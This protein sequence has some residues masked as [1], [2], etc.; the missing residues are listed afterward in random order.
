MK[1]NEALKMK[2]TAYFSGFNGLEIKDIEYGVD[3]YVIYITGAWN[4]KPKAHKS[5]VY[6]TD[7]PYFICKGI[8]VHID[9]CIRM[10]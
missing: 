1:T 3:D 10:Q 4:G 8:R 7:R 6:F 9:E 2:S 5:K